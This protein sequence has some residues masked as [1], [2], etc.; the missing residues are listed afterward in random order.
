VVKGSDR[1]FF[2]HMVHRIAREHQHHWQPSQKSL[3][4]RTMGI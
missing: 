4:K 3:K 1:D 2:Y